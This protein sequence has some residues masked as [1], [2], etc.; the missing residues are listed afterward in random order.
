MA[1]WTDELGEGK[2]TSPAVEV[3][4]YELFTSCGRR[5]EPWTGVAQFGV[6]EGQDN[7]QDE[8]DTL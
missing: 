3:A 4:L 1:L 6:G 5:R 7:T 8:S 2:P